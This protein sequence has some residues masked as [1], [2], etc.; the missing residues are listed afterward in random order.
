MCLAS[1]SSKSVR[2]W[3]AWLIEMEKFSLRLRLSVVNDDAIDAFDLRF[4][5]RWPRRC[6][7]LGSGRFMFAVLWTLLIL[8]V[9]HQLQSYAAA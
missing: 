1:V 4:V 7:L 3:S 5:R 2:E 9:E 8:L 6:W